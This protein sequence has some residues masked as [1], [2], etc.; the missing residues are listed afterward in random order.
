L[1]HRKYFVCYVLEDGSFPVGKSA[2]TA[3]WTI[4]PT[5]F[6]PLQNKGQ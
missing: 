6:W 2:K 4:L 3:F 1:C 5:G